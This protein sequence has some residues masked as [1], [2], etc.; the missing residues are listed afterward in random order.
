[1]LLWLSY[2]GMKARRSSV[3]PPQV[4]KRKGL[5][6]R[7][8]SSHEEHSKRWQRFPT[9]RDDYEAFL[10]DY[11]AWRFGGRNIDVRTKA[12]KLIQKIGKTAAKA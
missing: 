9:L 2:L 8:Q 6:L 10:C 5:V 1:M 12:K 3:T 7:M 4:F 11:L